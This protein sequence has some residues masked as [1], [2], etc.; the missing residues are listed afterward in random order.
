MQADEPPWADL[1]SIGAAFRS[2]EHEPRITQHLGDSATFD[3]KPFAGAIDLV[4]V[5]GAHTYDY[6]RADSKNALS[7]I[8]PG[9]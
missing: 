2:T 7:T 8:A 4:F 6:V 1:E 9:A 3:Y 5:D